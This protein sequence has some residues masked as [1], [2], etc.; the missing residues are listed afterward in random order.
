MAF[1]G[2]LPPLRAQVDSDQY[3]A[4][5]R[6][7]GTKA[8]SPVSQTCHDAEKHSHES[9]DE[10]P[11]GAKTDTITATFDEGVLRVEIDTPGVGQATGRRIEI[12]S[13]NQGS[14][15]Q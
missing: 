5:A 7:A 13:R 8:A 10:T 1:D 14:A 11:E 6:S 15:N 3:G 4:R 12:R 9:A 2:G